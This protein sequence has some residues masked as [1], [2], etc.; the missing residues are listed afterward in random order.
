MDEQR[1]DLTGMT[2]SELFALYTALEY[3]LERIAR[4]MRE[5]TM[6]A[7]PV[8]QREEKKS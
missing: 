5:L 8:E 2:Y 7:L 6:D 3:E 4:R 1:L